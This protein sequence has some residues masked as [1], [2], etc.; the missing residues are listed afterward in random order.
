VFIAIL[1]ITQ[2]SDIVKLTFRAAE[3]LHLRREHVFQF[4]EEAGV[5]SGPFV[6]GGAFF[7]LTHGTI[8]SAWFLTTITR[9]DHAMFAGW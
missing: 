5:P 3:N 2:I 1:S 7:L 8:A 9:I 4:R 6:G